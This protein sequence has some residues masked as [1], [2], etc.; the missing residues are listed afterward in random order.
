[1]SI[2]SIL[3]ICAL[4]I[5]FTVS[6]SSFAGNY[7]AIGAGSTTWDIKPVYGLFEVKDGPTL[8]LLLGIRNGNFA[9]EGEFTFSSHDWVGVSNATHNAGNL[10]IAGLG[11]LPISQSFELY[12][13]IGADYWK[14]TVD[15]GAYNF[16]GD[17]GVALVLGAGVNINIT[18]GFSLR[19]EYKRMN[20]LGDGVDKGDIGQSTLLAVF[21][22]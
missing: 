15:V 7:W 22:F 8:D 4:L 6:Q 3:K 19:A 20:G 10:I 21:K 1:M 11:F 2:K 18:Q 9:F 5:A 17:S 16:D 14:T 13:K 12:G